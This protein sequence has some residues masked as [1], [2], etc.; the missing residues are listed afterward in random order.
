MALK[1]LFI[2]VGLVHYFNGVLN[3]LDALENIEIINLVPERSRGHLEE[4]VYATNQDVTFKILSLPEISVTP[5]LKRFRGLRSLLVHEQPNIIVY[6]D[7]Y[8]N[9]FLFDW[10]VIKTVKRQNIRLVM[11]SIPFRINKYPDALAHADKLINSDKVLPKK[12][13]GNDLAWD[14]DI[15]RGIKRT[16]GRLSILLR[17]LSLNVPHA[18]VNYIEDAYEIYQSYGVPHHK[19]F[20]TSNSPDTDDLLSIRK[21]I[22]NDPPIIKKCDHRIIHVGRL[23]NGK[24]V[25]LLVHALVAV[26]KEI[27]DAELIVIG[28][29]PE[30]E[31]LVKLA[32]H[33]NVLDSI[34]FIGAIYDARLLGK[35]FLASSIYVLAGMGGLSINDAMCF[36]RPII[37]S[38]CD[39]TE[40]RLVR[41]GYNGL[42]FEQGNQKDLAQKIVYLLKNPRLQREMGINSVSIIENEVN[43]HTV[44]K[45]YL[46]AF[47]YVMR[48]CA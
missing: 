35:Y 7:Y 12:L 13:R 26:K 34:R 45:G 28:D 39:G 8:R 10:P 36:G 43:I 33:L 9:I 27:P 38:V 6:T 44:V 21:R 41:D 1:I 37:C 15:P 16:L 31:S 24:R 4:G 22:E 23:V 3:R 47:A 18:H 17:K 2:G 40:K 46:D 11:K 48:H 20:I 29:G 25:D 32:A 14:I 42:Y 30:K 19:I 5:L